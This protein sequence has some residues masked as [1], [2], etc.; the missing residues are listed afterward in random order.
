MYK[1]HNVSKN[2]LQFYHIQI[3]YLGHDGTQ[4]GKSLC[5]HRLEAIGDWSPPNYQKTTS[6][7][8]Q[9]HRIL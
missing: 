6:R 2:K 7:I 9:S 5:P 1:G 4:N 8:S 3:R